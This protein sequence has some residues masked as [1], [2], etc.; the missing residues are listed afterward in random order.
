MTSTPRHQFGRG[1]LRASTSE[2]HGRTHAVWI[3]GLEIHWDVIHVHGSAR[4]WKMGGFLFGPKLEKRC[5]ILNQ[6]R[7]AF[8]NG[9]FFETH[10]R[11]WQLALEPQMLTP[12]SGASWRPTP[13]LKPW[14]AD[15]FWA[16][17]PEPKCFI[18]LYSSIMHRVIRSSGQHIN[19][20]G[21]PKAY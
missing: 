3:S 1:P 2:Y 5:K 7:E 8:N 21:T 15:H 17:K 12:P 9:S 11:Q 4:A 10:S 6:T 18:E 14:H 16:L 19:R 13:C 20:Q